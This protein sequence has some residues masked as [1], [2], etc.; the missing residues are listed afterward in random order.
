MI[1]ISAVGFFMIF[2]FGTETSKLV[3][4]IHPQQNTLNNV[5]RKLRGANISAYK[6]ALN[7][8][9]EEINENYYK[10]KIRLSDC[11]SLLDTLRKGGL[12]KDYSRV[13][14]ELYDEYVLVGIADPVKV[15]IIEKALQNIEEME[16]LLEKIAAARISSKNQPI[17]GNNQVA[18]FDALAAATVA[19][20]TSLS[21]SLSK[22]W[23]SVTDLMKDKFN[24]S[25][26]LISLTF[27]A[28]A[29][30]SILFGFLIARNLI[31]PIKAITAKFK[32]FTARESDF[33]R[34]LPVTSRD[35][36]GELATEYNHLLETMEVITSFKKIIEEDENI[37]IIYLRIGDIITREIGFP[38]CFI[39][40]IGTIRNASKIVYSPDAGDADFS[41]REEVFT[42]VDACRV[43]R[44]GCVVSSH[45]NSRICGHFLGD[46]GDIHV[47]IPI[48]LSGVVGGVVQIIIK[49][50]DAESPEVAR[51]L[52]RT[53]EY[54]TEAQPVLSSKRAM[55]AYRELSV[56]D[57][58]TETYNRRFLQESA[59]T[60]T[61]GILRRGSFAALLMCDLDFFKDVN[62][63]HGHDVGDIVLKETAGCIKRIVRSSDIVVR[64]G[65]EEFLV[66]LMDIKCGGASTVA[67]KIRTAIEHHKVPIAGGF[68]ART[69]SIGICEIPTDTHSFWDAVKY[70]DIA[71]YKAK[72]TGRNR[73]V[74]FSANMIPEEE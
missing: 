30:L 15:A 35:E 24:L 61:A 3:D 63:Q 72:E 48:L 36:L 62:D 22:E 37:D 40:E 42:G 39:Y 11:R 49:R 59:D 44:T 60:I 23:G 27:A 67:E 34:K 2:D 33:A 13:T 55:R 6:I 31:I 52:G 66:L 19:G 70:A 51:K 32:A 50:N 43:K 14:G 38:R 17:A 45:K 53:Q 25:L 56:R 71:L 7:S 68:L 8:A 64:F 16:S 46:A 28:G 26:I 9:P 54:I 73:V 47:C 29:L 41:C 12:V 21:V 74:C 20:L 69:V 10:A 1:A 65:G 4:V 18:D 58:L 57:A 5:V